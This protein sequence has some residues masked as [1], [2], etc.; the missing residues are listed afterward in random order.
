MCLAS[1][2]FFI[3][4]GNILGVFISPLL[5]LLYLGQ[6]A[7][8]ALGTVFYKLCLRVL[9]PLFI[10]QL[11][12]SF[13]PLIVSFVKEHKP[14]F[15]KVQEYCLIFIVYT[16][17]CRTFYDQRNYGD[18]NKN[19]NDGTEVNRTTA[20]DAIIMIAFQFIILSLVMIIAWMLLKVLY[21]NQPTL[22]VMG[23]FGC[24]H[25]SVAVGIPLINAIYEDNKNI[26]FYTLP[27]LIWHPM[28]L[29]IGSF[30]S[31]RLAEFVTTEKESLEKLEMDNGVD[32]NV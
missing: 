3:A 29:V 21:P 16:V 13:S 25:K 7:S 30:L 6:S 24:S 12:H 27:L 15:K 8:I 26:G 32:D 1:F 31:P 18:Q 28:Q 10:G 19:Q 4:F 11:V 9:L 20:T 5:I 2:S 14:I 22:R 17:F 23:L